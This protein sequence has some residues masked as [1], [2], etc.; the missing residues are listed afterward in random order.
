MTD[1]NHL[2]GIRALVARPQQQGE[3]LAQAIAHAGGTALVL[4]MLEIVP[5]HENQAMR[6]Q[7]LSLDR[8]DKVIVISQ[9]AARYGLEHIENYWPQLP[10]H[11][12]WFAIGETTRQALAEFDQQAACSFS[13]I[14][15]ESLLAQADFQ[16]VAGQH[17]LLL[18]GIAGRDYLEQTLKK[19]GA[20]IS[21]LEVYQR[22]RPEYDPDKVRQLLAEHDINVIL[23]GSGETVKHL[24]HYLPPVYLDQCRLITPGPR[25]MKMAQTMGFQQVFAAAGADHAAMLVALKAINSEGSL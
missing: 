11:T 1:N 9:H 12:K 14:D 6:Q 13:G 18:K 19:Q 16:N 21:T 15:S 8:Y 4:P 25:V 5:L 17:I 2:F 24:C 3:A 20:I 23:A 7:I 10:L 22:Q